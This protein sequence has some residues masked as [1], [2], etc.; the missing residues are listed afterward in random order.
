MNRSG[1]S[2]EQAKTESFV[3]PPFKYKKIVAGVIRFPGAILEDR[4]IGPEFGDQAIP[5]KQILIL[6]APGIG[7]PI[8]G[9]FK[10]LNP[11]LVAVV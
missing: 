1:I 6:V 5:G 9:I 3:V 10:T 8:V 7:A 4:M 2:V 11:G